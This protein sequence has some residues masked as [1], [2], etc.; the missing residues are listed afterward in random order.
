[1]EPCLVRLLSFPIFTFLRCLQLSNIS[2][3]LIG[4]AYSRHIVQIYSYHG[5]DDIRQVLEV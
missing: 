5:G 4:V 2:F 3:L 1:M